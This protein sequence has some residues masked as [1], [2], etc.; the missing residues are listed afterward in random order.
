MDLRQ[1]MLDAIGE[2]SRNTLTLPLS[3]D[4][5][6]WLTERVQTLSQSES[7]LEQTQSNRDSRL[8]AENLSRLLAEAEARG[9][10]AGADA[11][12]ESLLKASLAGLCP[13]FPFC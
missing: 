9:R 10:S 11:V 1:A 12:D 13:I 3:P 7:Q 6:A 5:R 2:H 4:A 8:A